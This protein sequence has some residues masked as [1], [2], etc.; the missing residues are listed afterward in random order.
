MAVVSMSLFVGGKVYYDWRNRYVNIITHYK[1]LLLMCPSF[2]KAK[3]LQMEC[4]DSP[5]E[6]VLLARQPN[7]NEQEVSNSRN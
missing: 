6:R 7:I 1:G 2:I 4:N 5:A 3:F